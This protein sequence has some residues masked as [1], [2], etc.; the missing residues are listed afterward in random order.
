MQ[1]V[2]AIT[3]EL[4]AFATRDVGFRQFCDRY[5]IVS[6]DPETR[7]EYA[8][9]FDEAL[10]EEGMLDW[11]RQEGRDEVMPRLVESERKRKEDK[12]QIA[13]NLK[14]K[15]ILSIADIAETTGLSF[16]EVENA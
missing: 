5:E 6:A 8:M 3:P 12:I 15:G 13:R 14:H 16:E 7:R 1:E 2:V 4:Q 11:A 10:R 9:W